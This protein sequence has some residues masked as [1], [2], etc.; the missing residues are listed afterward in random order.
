M[1]MRTES[2]V[3]LSVALILVGSLGCGEGAMTPEE[4]AD[5]QPLP[6]YEAGPGPVVVGGSDAGTDSGPPPNRPGPTPDAGSTGGGG[7]ADSGAAGGGGLDSGA[8]GGGALDAGAG[9][10]DTGTGVDAAG[11]TPDQDAAAPD[12][13]QEGGTK[14]PDGT[15]ILPPVD[16][17]NK[18]GPFKV[19]IDTKPNFVV[20]HPTELGKDGLK[21]PVFVWGTGSG[22]L[23]E[24]YNDHFNRMASHGFVIVSPNK[25]QKSGTDMKAALDYILGENTKQGSTYYQKLDPERVAMGGHSQGSTSTFDAEANETRLKTTIHI[26][27]GSF[28]GQGS[29]KVKTPTAYICGETDIALNNCNR[30]FMNVKMQPTFYSVLQGV[31]HVQCA[32]EALPGMIAWL[33]WHLAGE[34]ERAKQFTGAEGD[35]FKGIWKSQTKNWKY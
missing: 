16:D 35:F 2:R 27:G 14:P 4:G 1:K 7:S 32:R 26:A 25:T 17:V 5:A 29:S 24:R 10:A 11:P 22:A 34:T 8:G 30:D 33:R 23:P 12:A 15:R 20:W 19:T 9:N 31:D 3:L 28:D 18:D 6:M 13:A 21:H